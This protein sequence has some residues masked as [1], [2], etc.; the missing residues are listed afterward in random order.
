MQGVSGSTKPVG[1]KVDIQ[2]NELVP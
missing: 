1:D 2:I